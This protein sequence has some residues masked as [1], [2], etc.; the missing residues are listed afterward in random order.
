MPPLYA[1]TRKGE[2][3]PNVQIFLDW[4]TGEQGQEL[5]EKSGYVGMVERQ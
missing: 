3:N 2:T 4:I 1:V 5:V